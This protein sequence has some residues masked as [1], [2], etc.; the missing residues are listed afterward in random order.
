M[1]LL[2]AHEY[3]L[4]GPGL[5]PKDGGYPILSALSKAHPWIHGRRDI[6]IAPLRGSQVP[7]FPQHLRADHATRLHVRG[8]TPEEAMKLGWTTLQVFNGLLTTNIPLTVNLHPG[9]KLVS[10]HVIFNGITDPQGFVNFFCERTGLR[11]DQV[12]LG[13]KKFMHIKNQIWCGYAVIL[14]GLSEAES[15]AIQS[16]GVGK[17]TSMGCGVFYCRK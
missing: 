4:T 5:I 7:E 1:Y 16:H 2:Q 6:Q 8:L 17:N 14:T 15:Y 11:P 9:P 12:T 10:K 13:N 3:T